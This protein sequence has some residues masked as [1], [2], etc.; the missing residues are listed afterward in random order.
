MSAP[1]DSFLVIGEVAGQPF[2][3]QGK[4]PMPIALFDKLIAGAFSACHVRVFDLTTLEITDL[5]RD[6]CPPGSVVL[7]AAI[8]PDLLY[9]VTGHSDDNGG[10]IVI[11]SM[12]PKSELHQI[13]TVDAVTKICFGLSSSEV[14]ATN[15]TGSIFVAEVKAQSRFALRRTQ[16]PCQ[17][18]EKCN[19]S[20]PVN[21]M[22]VY[23]G[24]CECQARLFV[25]TPSG[26][27]A[28]S[29]RDY[30]VAW[31]DGHVSL[32]F[33]FYDNETQILARGVGHTVLLSD[34]QGENVRCFSFSATPS[35]I[36]VIDINAV[37]VLFAGSCEMAKM[38][39]EDD[40]EKF[41]RAVQ[42]GTSLAYGS[43]IFIVGQD[44]TLLRLTLASVKDRVANYRQQKKWTEALS[45]ISN[46]TDVDNLTELLKAYAASPE[47]DPR[48][49]FE[50]IGRLNVHD[51]F[52][53]GVIKENRAAL[54]T[55][56]VE[57][58]V[59][60]WSLNMGFIREL[61]DFV[62]DD[63]KLTAF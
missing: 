14:I 6:S 18:N 46:A 39:A 35:T 49:L 32:C 54:V 28:L 61:F 21:A 22:A 4:P 57:Q 24:K 27:F 50:T 9:V 26:T 20:V 33:A 25:S 2:R 19:M 36:S 62:E 3:E 30:Q 48:V 13:T 15:L 34:F 5:R 58:K 44:G 29:T 10:E 40:F 8:S 11:W 1:E 12:P 42:R 45:L 52:V 55:A 37:L 56:F 43:S 59:M 47:C 38:R 7:C 31:Q 16:T 63:D 17:V 60:N 53:S 51:T 41:S 23:Y